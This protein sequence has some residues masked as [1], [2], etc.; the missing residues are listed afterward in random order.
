LV[1]LPDNSLDF[2]ALR[3]LEMVPMSESL[4]LLSHSLVD[5]FRT[6][7]VLGASDDSGKDPIAMGSPM[8]GSTEAEDAAATAGDG[9]GSPSLCGSKLRITSIND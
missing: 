7:I 3:T 9:T 5:R 8:A 1:G 6:E 4:T 2:L